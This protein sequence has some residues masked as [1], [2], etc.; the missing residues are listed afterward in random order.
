MA[1]RSIKQPNQNL[2]IP[3]DTAMWNDSVMFSFKKE[4]QEEALTAIPALPLILEK[5]AK[6]GDKVWTWFG[7]EA[8]EESQGYYWDQKKGICSEEDD[9]MDNIVLEWNM[10]EYSSDDEEGGELNT[11]R[12]FQA[13]FNDMGNKPYDDASASTFGSMFS[14][15]STH[16]RAPETNKLADDDP[17]NASTPD[18]NKQ[19][20]DDPSSITN[21]MDIDTELSLQQML[22]SKDPNIRAQVLTL[23]SKGMQNTNL[24]AARQNEAGDSD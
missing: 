7:A 24:Q 14:R 13:V 6:L 18:M 8:K 17:P 22:D 15:V 9:L 10:N 5:Q 4:F 23:L 11:G 19:P 21:D 12:A 20:D 3:V 1:L 2:F 16:S